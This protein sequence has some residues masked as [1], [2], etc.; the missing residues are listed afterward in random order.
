MSW[1]CKRPAH[2]KRHKDLVCWQA[3]SR[4]LPTVFIKLDPTVYYTRQDTVGC[5]TLKVRGCY[6]CAVASK[7]KCEFVALREVEFTYQAG[8]GV[9]MTI[10]RQ[11]TEKGAVY[12]G[13]LDDL[14]QN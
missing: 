2:S 12:Q 5:A 11:R 4:S 1:F 6:H 3:E 8:Q 9:E 7:S 13:K 10:D 14:T